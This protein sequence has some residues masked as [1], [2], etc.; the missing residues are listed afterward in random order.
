M[1]TSKKSDAFVKLA[2]AGP[3]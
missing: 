2:K 1:Y 3:D